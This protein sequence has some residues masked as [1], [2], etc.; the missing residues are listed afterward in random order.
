ML[1][2]SAGLGEPLN[3]IIS[4]QSSPEV[5]TDAGPMNWARSIGFSNEFLDGNGALPEIKVIREDFYLP[6][7]IGTG[8]ESLV[9]GNHFKYWRQNGPT[10]NTGALFLAVSHEMDV[11]HHYDI[12]SGGYDQGRNELVKKAVGKTSFLGVRYSTTARKISRLLEPGAKRINH[13]IP[14]DGDVYLLT[15]K[16]Q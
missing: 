12:V 13:G 16:V 9:G 8:I 14:I 7:T 5:L 2:T 1:D 6:F 15:I 3:V 10:A 4:G 11:R